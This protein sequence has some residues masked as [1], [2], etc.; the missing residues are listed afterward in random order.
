MPKIPM[1]K[2]EVGL[3]AAPLG[4]RANMQAATQVGRAFSDLGRQVT[5]SAS[6]AATAV[7][8][9][10][11]R[12]EALEKERKA[13]KKKLAERQA[14]AAADALF[15]DVRANVI[16]KQSEALRDT[17]IIGLDAAA[18]RITK[19]YDEANA[20]VESF[21]SDGL[22][23][24]IHEMKMRTNLTGIM[25][26]VGVNIEKHGFDTL[27]TQ[28]KVKFDESVQTDI[29][30]ARADPSKIPLLVQSYANAFEQRTQDGLNPAS[31][32]A[33]ELSL[34]TTSIDAM[35]QDSATTYTELRLERDRIDDAEGEYSSLERGA[36]D[37]LV[38]ILNRGIEEK[39]TIITNQ[40]SEEAT[41]AMAGFEV[42]NSEKG[43][44]AAIDQMQRAIN[45]YTSIEDVANVS[46]YQ[47]I[48]D[49][50]EMLTPVI[51]EMPH[52]SEEDINE[53]LKI[54]RAA[55]QSAIGTTGLAGA[56][57]ARKSVEAAQQAR[58]EAIAEDSAK[59]SQNAL[60]ERFPNSE[61][62]KS[63]IVQHQRDIG[64]PDESVKV[65]TSAEVA[66]IMAN[67]SEAQ[68]PEELSAI[69]ES[70]R[71]V[72]NPDLVMRQLR[73]N[74]LSVSQ[75]FI[76]ANPNSDISRTALIA[77]TSDA[78]TGANAPTKTQ[79]K[80]VENAVVQNETFFSQIKSM[81][82]ALMVGMTSDDV[83]TEGVLTPKMQATMDGMKAMVADTAIYLAVND[84]QM[85]GADGIST[86]DEMAKYVEQAVNIISQN[87]TYAEINEGTTR[88]PKAYEGRETEISQ[89]I[90][91]LV[92]TL[93]IED[94]FYEHPQ[95][96][97][98]TP[99]YD[100]AK[101]VYFNELME[102]YKVFTVNGDKTAIIT[103]KVGGA[104]RLNP[105]SPSAVSDEVF[106]VSFAGAASTNQ[107]EGRA[108]LDSYREK[109]QEIARTIRDHPKKGEANQEKIRAL[110]AQRDAII[111]SYNSYSRYLRSKDL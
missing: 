72:G 39:E 23:S 93:N 44:K 100:A 99:E 65:Y 7:A 53:A 87:Y 81:G 29:E 27:Q 33:Y 92:K 83:L 49:T 63:M 54:V 56:V 12:Q 85:F 1:Y 41:N 48:I 15:Q 77:S 24:D 86:P 31:V 98:G 8:Q 21:K 105:S 58:A 68:T 84:K 43:A 70:A 4:P 91:F 88:L 18:E 35:V 82:G 51:V 69:L 5:A 75:M 102:N 76:A 9:E 66:E 110:N 111:K 32:D 26:N 101:Q 62:T 108:R 45:L 95:F 3:T 64:V 80:F 19:I 61:P 36:R 59:Y 16:S 13:A 94:V 6:A 28:N 90:D 74:G 46:K 17:S 71:S 34:Y 30:E 40:A 55:E 67:V 57:A 25:S 103:D 78:V 107:L 73:E 14:D 79:R 109:A 89:G 106:S 104:V 37:Q 97:P 11:K 20:M 52:S 10:R 38:S 2:R 22:I 96:K 50:M 60:Q 42:A 47:T